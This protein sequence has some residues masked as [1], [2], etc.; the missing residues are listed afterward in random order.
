MMTEFPFFGGV[1]NY[2]FNLVTFKST[3]FTVQYI[4]ENQMRHQN[5]SNYCKLKKLIMLMTV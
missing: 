5:R 3:K 1:A 4:T 2:P